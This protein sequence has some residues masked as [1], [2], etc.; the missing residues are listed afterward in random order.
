MVPRSVL[1]DMCSRRWDS[2]LVSTWQ[3]PISSWKGSSAVFLWLETVDGKTR[4]VILKATRHSEGQRRASETFPVVPGPPELWAYQRAGAQLDAFLPDCLL[5]TSLGDTFVYV[6]EDLTREYG[7]PPRAGGWETGFRLLHPLHE[8]M[9]EAVE[10][11]GSEPLL[12]YDRAFG[13]RLMGYAEEGIEAFRHDTHSAPADELLTVWKTLRAAYLSPEFDLPELH[14]PVHGDYNTGNLFVARTGRGA[15]KV[16]DWEWAGIGLPHMDLA[17]YLRQA[18]DDVVRWALEV[19][20]AQNPGLTAL[21][22]ERALWRCVL[23]RSVWD[24][25]LLASQSKAEPERAG[26]LGPG[27]DR[28]LQTAIAALARL[29]G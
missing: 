15:L 18:P 6:L 16:V 23:E 8:A 4:R 9:A 3:A 24:A 28:A 26:R 10:A 13:E 20:S 21:E 7:K 25:S 19:F 2:A 1:G 27:I 14:R 5:A 11:H 17:S 22:H 29:T 12:I